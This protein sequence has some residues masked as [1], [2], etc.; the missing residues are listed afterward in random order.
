MELR[1]LVILLVLIPNLVLGAGA[2]V[3]SSVAYNPPNDALI[4]HTMGEGNG[5]GTTVR[6][7][8]PISKWMNKHSVQEQT[9]WDYDNK[10][11]GWTGW[12]ELSGGYATN[13][14]PSLMEETNE[15]TV[16]LWAMATTGMDPVFRVRMGTI[17]P[18]S[19]SWNA[20]PA[21]HE[22]STGGAWELS[23]G[24]FGY[25]NPLAVYHDG[26][27]LGP[28]GSTWTTGTWYCVIHSHR[29]VGGAVNTDI[30]KEWVNGLLTSS[31]DFDYG[32]TGPYSVG[33]YFQIGA[34]WN[35]VE[36][37][38]WHGYIGQVLMFSTYIGEDGDNE[39]RAWY[40]RGLVERGVE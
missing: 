3:L 12:N 23:A 14:T 33:E 29:Q 35:T 5:G 17:A 9:P 2:L 7:F 34:S 19:Y 32:T 16:I 10:S 36:T 24:A 11:K 4:V 37:R 21:S 15:F 39:A 40:Q 20:Q 25:N 6:N 31:N 18:R 8:S 38:A 27:G 30:S 1:A 13:L 22:H 26:A 28:P